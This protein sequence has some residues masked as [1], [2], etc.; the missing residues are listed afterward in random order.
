MMNINNK[1]IEKIINIILG[2]IFLSSGLYMVTS[3]NYNENII[4]I[5]SVFSFGYWCFKD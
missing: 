3:N 5:L 1:L 4:V 2:L